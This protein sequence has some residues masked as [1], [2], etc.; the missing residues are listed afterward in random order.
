ME[1][2]SIDT[3]WA[4]H[5]GRLD[6]ESAFEPVVFCAV[7]MQSG[8]RLHF[9][10]RDD[11]LAEFI[12]AAAEDIFVA[13]SATAE[14]KYLLRLGIPLPHRWFDT[15]VAFRVITNRPN[16]LEAGLTVA[17]H[18]L[19]LPHLAPAEK[20]ELRR[21]IVNLEFNQENP[22]DKLEII[23]YCF[24]D[25]DGAAA[26]Y[27]RL[28]GRVAD[29]TMQHWIEYLKAVARMELRGIPLDMDYYSAIEQKR[30]A[31]RLA[32][33]AQVNREV[34]VFENGVFKKQ[35]FLQFCSQQGINWPTKP[36]PAGGKPYRPL[37]DETMKDMEGR[38]P[39]IGLVR[40]ARKT[41]TSLTKR[42]LVVDHVH[43]RHYFST[44]PFRS[45][46]GRNQPRSFIFSG[47]KW[48]RYLIVPESPD[49][50]LVYVDYTGQEIG[51]A[52]GLSRDPVMTEMYAEND[53]HMAFAIR[54]AAAPPGATKQTHGD[55]RKQYKTVNLGVQY[56]QTD[57]GIAVKL[58]I[59]I[60]AAATIIRAHQKLFPHFWQWSE[61]VVQGAMDAGYIRTPCGWRSRVPPLH[62]DR[63]WRN[64]PMQSTGADVMRLTITYLDR[65]NVRV[66]APVH[67]GFLLSCRRDQLSDLR[68]AVSFA[69]GTAVDQVLPGF[70]LKWD[71][72]VYEERFKDEDGAAMWRMVQQALAKV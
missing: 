6:Q 19:G 45:V 58:G 3:E 43:G 56:G 37:D 65:Q 62:N 22:A 4:F 49:H 46:T 30:E 66:L 33:I 14:M 26:L 64:W 41:L 71:F 23:N 31:I 53:C 20:E 13:H 16:H 54:A 63:T 27:E 10:S 72:T 47:P 59:P 60:S 55:V 38:H 15:F 51:I 7:G 1:I 2:W 8:T 50:V 42:S 12:A 52:A 21:R 67:D 11:R 9:W 61:R 39:S 68:E 5:D 28:V 18:Q 34:P 29:E 36:S 35:A 69:C 57:Y 48:W 24:T 44:N 25:C 17:L 40:Q 70:R 32:L